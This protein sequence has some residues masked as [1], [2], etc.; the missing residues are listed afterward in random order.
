MREDGAGETVTATRVAGVWTVQD[1]LGKRTVIEGTTFA[2]PSLASVP[3]TQISGSTLEVVRSDGE[4]GEIV[5]TSLGGDD[6]DHM[7]LSEDGVN[8]S[9]AFDSDGSGVVDTLTVNT[10]LNVGGSDLIADI[11]GP[12]PKGIVSAY[13]FP[14]NSASIGNNECGIVDIAFDAEPG[15]TYRIVFDGYVYTSAAARFQLYFRA[16]SSGDGSSAAPPTLASSA[17]WG[18]G[19]FYNPNSGGG[20]IREH[21]ERTII[22][23][24]DYSNTSQY[25]VL[26]SMN[27]FTSGTSAQIYAAEKT[28]FYVED[29]GNY[30]GG[31]ADAVKNNGG[32]SPASGTIQNPPAASVKTYTSSWAMNAWRS[33]RGSGTVSDY[34]QQGYYG[35]Y[36][37]YSVLLW[38]S[39][40]S[41]AMSGYKK[42][43]GMWLYIKNASWYASAGGTLRLGHY[44][45]TAL[46]GSPQTAGG[47]AVSVAMKP[48]QGLWIGLPSGWWP[49]IAA[50]NIRGFTLGEGANSSG[51]YY[52]KFQPSGVVLKAT[53]SK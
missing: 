21:L 50:G 34:L 40:P 51:T 41:S 12:L 25:R 5:T 4:D 30:S 6:G 26:L 35:G 16:R 32:G 17:L 22:A 10:A 11:I 23:N 24:P 44:N 13:D 31:W 52:G 49:D 14:E 42:I 9:V 29:V 38:G 53:Y 39:N 28:Q 2:T 15:R 47:G 36:Q 19:I 1:V 3:R 20:L 33:W 18:S 43:T 27:T 46:P 7:Q 48:G 45:S 37:R 8:P